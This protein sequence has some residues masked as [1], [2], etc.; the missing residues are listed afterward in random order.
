MSY[1]RTEEHRAR[2]G[3]LKRTNLLGQRLGRLLVVRLY[4][5]GKQ[6]QTPVWTCLCDCGQAVNVR[7]GELRNGDTRSCGC[8]RRERA[9][10]MRREA[11]RHGHKAGGKKS[12]TYGSWKSMNDRCHYPNNISYP[13]YGAIGRT[14]CEEWRTVC[15]GGRPGAF[16]RFLAYLMESGIGLR[17]EGMTLDRIDNDRGYEPG[18]IRWATGSEQAVNRPQRQHDERGR[19]V[20]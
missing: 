1:E 5:R 11:T 4:K 16:E 6:G 17:P 9:A 15:Y 12:P 20:A 18:N 7:A 10:K 13:N 14:V 19:F 8:L 2:M 3:D